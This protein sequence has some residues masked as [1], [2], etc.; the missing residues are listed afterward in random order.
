MDALEYLVSKK[1]SIIDI[2][3]LGFSRRANNKDWSKYKH[4]FGMEYAK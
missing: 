1:V 2:D 4:L 3:V